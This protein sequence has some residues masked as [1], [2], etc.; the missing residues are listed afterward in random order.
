[1]DSSSS[2]KDAKTESLDAPLHA[3]GFQIDELSPHKVTGRLPVTHKACQPFKVLHG[4]VSALIAE[5]LASMGAHMASGWKRVAGLQLSINHLRRADLGDLVF[6]EAT[7]IHAGKTIQVWEV[8]LWK[9]D[10]VNSE[11]KS[12]IS[13]S[14]VTLI[15]NLPVPEDGKDAAKY[16]KKYAKL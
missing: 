2:N 5:A 4:G 14:R 6:A 12:L 11:K 3:I 7:P 1:M 8:R 15:T 10:P 16:L 13:S 9:I